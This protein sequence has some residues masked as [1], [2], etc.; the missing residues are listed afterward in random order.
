MVFK[1]SFA[2]F[3]E[4]D[5]LLEDLETVFAGPVLYQE[6]EDVLDH[7]EVLVAEGENSGHES[8]KS[9]HDYDVI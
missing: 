2:P 6:D 8:E 9:G 4:L 5:L 7:V 3:A 1:T